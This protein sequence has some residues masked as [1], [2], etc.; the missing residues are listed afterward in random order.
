LPTGDRGHRCLLRIGE[1]TARGTPERAV[2]VGTRP[3]DAMDRGCR[4][5]VPALRT[6]DPTNG[7]PVDALDLLIADHNRVRGLFARFRKA[8]EHEEA[9][10]M[11]MLAKRIVEELEV[12]TTIEEEI[13]YPAIRDQDEELSETVDESL[14]EHHVVDVLMNEMR[15]LADGSDEWVAK[16]TVLIENVEHHADEEEQELFPAVRSAFDADVLEDQARR[17]EARKEQLA[18]MPG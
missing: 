15:D 5:G 17:F 14:Q 10:D 16:M 3:L 13:F 12:H 1:F 8:E 4:D 7:D 9:E 11:Q 2:G 6:A 18:S